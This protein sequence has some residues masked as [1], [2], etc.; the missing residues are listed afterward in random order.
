MISLEQNKK[1]IG[2]ETSIES[3][4]FKNQIFFQGAIVSLRF[5]NQ[6]CG[7]LKS[8]GCLL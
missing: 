7:S 1:K 4:T 5:Q 3:W 2:N 8:D 6:V